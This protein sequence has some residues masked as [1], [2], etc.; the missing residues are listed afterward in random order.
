LEDREPT[1]ARLIDLEDQ[2]LEERRLVLDGKA[3]L[4]LMIRPVP[5]I[6]GGDIAIAAHRRLNIPAA[7]ATARRYAR[8]SRRRPRGSRRGS[9]W[10]RPAPACAGAWARSAH[11]RARA[12][13]A[14]SR[15]RAR[16]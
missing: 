2:T 13:P 9:R 7:A 11:G 1:Q 12:S 15:P 16:P 4:P 3:I 14:P 10:R 6:A 5:G 8:G